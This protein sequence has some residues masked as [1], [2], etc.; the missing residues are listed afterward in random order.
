MASAQLRVTLVAASIGRERELIGFEEVRDFASESYNLAI[1]SLQAAAQARPELRRRLRFERLDFEITWDRRVLGAEAVEA[2]AATAPDIVGLSCY[3]WSVDLL[4]GLLPELRRRC[5]EAL[6][7]LGGPSAGPVA[8]EL[9]EARPEVDVVVTGEGE[10]SFVALLE[11]QLEG[12]PLSAVAGVASRG[13]GG[14]VVIAEP[15]SPLS[16]ATLPSVYRAGVLP[17]SG[18]SL[19]LETSRGCRSR[20]RFCSWTGGGRLRYRPIAEVEADLRWAARQGVRSVKLAD[21][22]INFDADRLEALTAALGRADPE[23]RLR[24]TYFLKPERLD[25][26]QLSLLRR[27]PT[28]ELI[29]GVES[30]DDEVRRAVG[31]PPIDLEA[32]ERRLVGLGEVG[33][34]T[35]SLILG[36]PGDT[37]AGLI[38]TL[39]W[40]IDL[41]QRRPGL[42]HVICLFWLA[43]LPGSRLRARAEAWGDRF[44]SSETPYLLESDDHDP[45]TL[46]TMARLAIE[47]HFRH[48]RLRVEYFHQEYLQQDAAAEDRR[49][50]IPRRQPDERPVVALLGGP[51]RAFGELVAHGLEP[52]FAKAYAEAD[53][54]IGRRWRLELLH[55]GGDGG[56]EGALESIARLS[57]RL[58]LWWPAAA[59]DP[60]EV[61]EQIRRR[62]AE[63][64]ILLVG[65]NPSAAGPADGVIAGEAERPLRQLL[66]GDRLDLDGVRGVIRSGSGEIPEQGAAELVARLDEI[67]SPFQWG[68]VARRTDEPA[69]LSLGRPGP[70]RRFFSRERLA[71]DLRWALEAGFRRVRW[72]GLPLPSAT[73]ELEALGEVLHEVDPGG[74]QEHRFSA[75]PRTGAELRAL[76]AA[77]PG[78]VSLAGEEV[79]LSRRL[80]AWRRG[81]ELGGWRL[82]EV[83]EGA[84]R[85]LRCRSRQGQDVVVRLGASGAATPEPCDAGDEAVARLLAIVRRLAR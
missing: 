12:R 71:G 28:E 7:L 29:V 17:A 51:T 43:L 48:P 49:V 22:A 10:G 23:R 45:S 36:L 56:L 76:V 69:L 62:A 20:C 1:G 37:A 54:A 3:C 25:E 47:R 80:A 68:F 15:P 73:V 52:L 30:V 83:V 19:L 14:E 81:G 35:A 72:L 16:L 70:P 6:V 31:K 57:P 18:A 75:D 8:A 33:P 2:V 39:D 38:R 13:A 11:A 78:R 4:L 53:E 42:L 27:L 26:W 50:S 67:P 59:I 82:V 55:L 84:S 9:L 44:M 66:A 77:A 74:R 46:L 64:T 41:D 65:A 85:R 61:I 58:L 5:P 63:A 60:T 34:V 24:L 79:D 32:Y 40:M 21:T